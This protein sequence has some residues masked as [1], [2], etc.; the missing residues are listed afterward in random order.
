MERPKVDVVI[1]K[2]INQEPLGIDE[3]I[4]FKETDFYTV[5][6]NLGDKLD[7]RFDSEKP[8]N[9]P[10]IINGLYRK[11]SH[12]LSDLFMTGEMAPY[13]Y[14]LSLNE[15]EV[16]DK[17]NHSLDNYIQGCIS[18]KQITND[19]DILGN[20]KTLG[21]RNGERSKYTNIGQ[22]RLISLREAIEKNNADAEILMR[23]V[24]KDGRP[25]AL[26]TAKKLIENGISVFNYD[27]GEK[28]GTIRIAKIRD[29]V[30]TY[31][32]KAIKYYKEGRGM[33]KK[34][35]IRD[36][37]NSTGITQT[38]IKDLEDN[39][40]NMSIYHGKVLETYLN[41]VNEEMGE[42]NK[43]KIIDEEK[44]IFG[45]YREFF[46]DT[47]EAQQP[48]K[49]KYWLGFSIFEWCNAYE[50]IS[51]YISSRNKEKVTLE[52]INKY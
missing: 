29:D 45:F 11:N 44:G 30:N 24:E 31:V 18:F 26:D 39:P 47:I 7:I 20:A 43:I 28:F 16:K 14:D 50:A 49:H 13:Q 6:E 1:E 25:W 32:E 5:M 23:V 48:Q 27:E 17:F 52:E 19:M 10:K 9:F 15:I 12:F 35:A 42:T 36:M 21:Y 33:N 8:I 46:S 3:A 40:N 51:S 34:D 38:V 4:V 41:R 22:R 37:S 2:V